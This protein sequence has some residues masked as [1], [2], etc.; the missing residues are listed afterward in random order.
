MERLPFAEE[1]DGE[2]ADS[3]PIEQHPVTVHH[4]LPISGVSGTSTRAID[5]RVP[6]AEVRAV[7]DRVE[8]IEVVGEAD[9]V[10]FDRHRNCEGLSVG[11]S[12]KRQTTP[13]GSC[14][15]DSID[16]DYQPQKARKPPNR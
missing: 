3:C 15:S 1:T 8:T 11:L 9:W 14:D 10:F 6:R 16:P 12:E 4:G 13:I 5:N 7:L 2:R